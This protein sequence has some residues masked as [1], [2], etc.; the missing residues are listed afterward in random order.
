MFTKCP[1]QW[2]QWPAVPFVSA[3][4]PR[5]EV[6]AE[7]FR[8]PQ[9]PAGG[10]VCCVPAC[11]CRAWHHRRQ[12]AGCSGLP[13][14]ASWRRDREPPVHHRQTSLPSHVH[15]TRAAGLGGAGYTSFVDAGKPLGYY[16]QALT[17]RGGCSR[18]RS[19]PAHEARLREANG[20]SGPV[21]DSDLRSQGSTI[22]VL[23]PDPPLRL[24]P[25]LLLLHGCDT[26]GGMAGGCRS[27]SERRRMR[28]SGSR[29]SVI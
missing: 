5:A 3:G 19:V 13:L 4:S 16:L 21:T 27:P 8:G 1:S 7:H 29:S 2:P 25:P 9:G 6:A 22:H 28:C 18:P 24:R 17:A 12:W 14:V 11:S 10:A 23:T 26:N 15:G 20:P